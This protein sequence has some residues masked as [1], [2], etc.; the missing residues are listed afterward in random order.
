LAQGKMAD[1]LV[2][3]PSEVL[4]TK[5]TIN[6]RFKDGRDLMDVACQLARSDYQEQDDIVM[7]V[8]VHFDG[9]VFTLDNRMLAVF[10]MLEVVEMLRAIRVQIVAKPKSTWHVEFGKENAGNS[11]WVRGLQRKMS[12]GRFEEFTPARMS[13]L[14]QVVA[15]R[16][17]STHP[18]FWVDQCLDVQADDDVYQDPEEYAVGDVEMRCKDKTINTPLW[19]FK[20][21]KRAN[22]TVVAFNR[23][24]KPRR[25]VYINN[26]SLWRRFCTEAK[27]KD[28]PMPV[29]G[30]FHHFNSNTGFEADDYAT[31][32]ALT[33]FSYHLSGGRFLLCDL[34]G[35][36]YPDHYIL[37]DPIIHSFQAGTNGPADLGTEGIEQF[38]S[39]HRC[40]HLCNPDWAWP[41]TPKQHFTV[42][43]GTTYI[44]HNRLFCVYR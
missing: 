40:S 20:V 39:Q 36:A 11:V 34:R 13:E 30:P 37:T 14:R 7:K 9:G 15:E 33:H 19:G 32:A 21:L 43:K 35:F 24:I 27:D 6:P 31:M 26:G 1:T 8:V 38:F 17:R 41:A 16:L 28:Y 29:Q 42:V 2:I 10:R 18:M 3:A 44:M 4:F 25:T 22:R 23:S 12:F 5:Q